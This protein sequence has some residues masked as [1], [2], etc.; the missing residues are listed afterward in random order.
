[1][2]SFFHKPAGRQESKHSTRPR[3]SK[4]A[5]KQVRTN[6]LYSFGATACLPQQEGPV[7]RRAKV[8]LEALLLS[9]LSGFFRRLCRP[10]NPS[11][12]TGRTT[13]LHFMLS[14]YT[15]SLCRTGRSGRYR[16]PDYLVGEPP[17]N[18]VERGEGAGWW[19]CHAPEKIEERTLE[20][21]A[22]FA[23]RKDD[24]G[25]W[26][27]WIESSWPNEH[28]ETLNLT[29]CGLIFEKSAFLSV[30]PGPSCS[31]PRR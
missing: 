25:P 12:A 17:K 19:W 10:A 4:A 28:V 11:P 16:S 5:P 22:I 14:Y 8:W 30:L 2:S 13:T 27:P 23:D 1:M 21:V 24:V 7:G 31:A 3:S 9:L 18:D 26:R 15:S 6:I 20:S 29:Q